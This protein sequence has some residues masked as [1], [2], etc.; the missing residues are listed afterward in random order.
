MRIHAVR[1]VNHALTGRFARA[2]ETFCIIK[3]EDTFKART[4]ATRTDKWTDEYHLIEVDKA[5][6]IE[7]T[8]YDKSGT[9][10]T[11]IGMLWIR[12][13]DLVE[14]MRRKKIESELSG[15]QW[16]TAEQMDRGGGS[17]GG[18]GGGGGMGSTAGSLS[19][20]ST[21]VNQPMGGAQRPQGHSPGGDGGDPNVIEAWFSLEPVGSIRLSMSFCMFF[22]PD[23]AL[24]LTRI[25]RNKIRANRT[26]TS[27]LAEKVLCAN[28]KKKSWSNT[29]TS[30]LR[31]NSTALCVALYAANF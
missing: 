17:G 19:S 12:I 13:S 29:G 4:R 21:L 11:P 20:G 23:V 2:P 8:V 18:G 31:S 6:E 22:G 5:N 27:A 7:V 15:S 3:V 9:Y 30:S 14:E 1:E 24:A 28:A 26:L 10:P 16:V 25:Q